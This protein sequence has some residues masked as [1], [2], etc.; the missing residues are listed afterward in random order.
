MMP[1][2]P[3]VRAERVPLSPRLRALI[4]HLRIKPLRT[5]LQEEVGTEGSPPKLASK[6]RAAI[7]KTLTYNISAARKELQ[8]C[9][10]VQ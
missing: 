8:S 2:L 1:P 3:A 9:L 7:F 6:H 4:Q 10:I 5:K